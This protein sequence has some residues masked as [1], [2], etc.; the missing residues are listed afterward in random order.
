MKKILLIVIFCALTFIVKSQNTSVEKSTS[1]IQT[2]VVGIWVHNEV[3]LS[4]QIAMRSELGFNGGVFGGSFYG[5]GV[6]I[7]MMPVITLEP[8]WYYNLD[9]RV[10]KS[11]NISG[12]SGNFISLK[13]SYHPDW[14]VITNRKGWN[15]VNRVSIIPTWGIRRNIGNHF[16]YESAIGI[17]YGFLFNRS[18]G[19]LNIEGETAV[20]VH[21]RIGYRF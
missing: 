11:R 4:N 6:V 13:A 1:G 7:L 10:L 8:R 3:R 12:N 2:G 14:F 19:N 16:S 21:L 17:G 5:G 20:N 18:T 15:A 9:K